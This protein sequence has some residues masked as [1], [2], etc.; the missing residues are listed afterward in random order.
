[1]NN[2]RETSPLKERLL[3]SAREW[4][5]TAKRRIYC[6]AECNWP[7]RKKTLVLSRASLPKLGIEFF[8]KA[9][10][11]IR[12]REGREATQAAKSPTALVAGVTFSALA[13]VVA[14]GAAAIFGFAKGRT[15]Q[16]W[17][18]VL[19]RRHPLRHSEVG[20]CGINKSKLEGASEDY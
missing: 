12:E 4:Q 18:S 15:N 19:K 3:D 10:I 7:L 16:R 5:E 8:K 9:S 14:A 6:I 2:N 20:S 11:A 13:I 1:M 17:G